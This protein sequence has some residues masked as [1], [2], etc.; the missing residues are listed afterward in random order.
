MI[1]D[2]KYTK[3]K[4]ITTLKSCKLEIVLMAIYSSTD[5]E[6]KGACEKIAEYSKHSCHTKLFLSNTKSIGIEKIAMSEV[7]CVA[8]TK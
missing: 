8:L 5:H 6:K 4:T 7:P 1:T 3:S 2:K